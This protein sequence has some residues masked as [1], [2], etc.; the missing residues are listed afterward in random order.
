VLLTRHGLSEHN[1]QTQLYM[2]RSPASR[3]VAEG[4]AQARALGAHLARREAVQRIVASSLPRALETATL[5]A[6][7]LGGVPV[8]A[9]DAFWE[10]SKGDWEGRMPRDGVPEPERSAWELHPFGFRFPQGESF[11][12]VAARVAP[13]F[14]E[15]VGCYGRERLLFV[16]HG[17]V[18]CALLQHLLGTPPDQV[19]CYLVPP[20]SLTEVARANG[21]WRLAR[22]GEDGFL[23][24]EE[25]GAAPR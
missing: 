12:L 8:H 6:A 7:E 2:G 3:L 1:L 20:C 13:A 25:G 16:L 10:L 5:V 17:D 19:R 21:A 11:A 18:V 22:F 9:D 15:W 4:R 23:R 14:A 24:G